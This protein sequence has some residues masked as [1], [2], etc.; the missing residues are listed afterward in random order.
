MV[1][2][3][4][5]F[6]NFPRYFFFQRAKYTAPKSSERNFTQNLALFILDKFTIFSFTFNQEKT[7]LRKVF[8]RKQFFS[9]IFYSLH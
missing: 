8:F 3:S 4:K 2:E 6:E 9:T 7:Q 5:T 1:L